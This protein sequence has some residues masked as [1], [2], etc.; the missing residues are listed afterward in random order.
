M[1]TL[2]LRPWTPDHAV[3]DNPPM[4]RSE[5][6]TLGVRVEVESELIRERSDATRN[7]WFFA[8][9]VQITNEGSR[10]VQL[11]SR[12]WIISDANGAVE[13]V[14]GRGVVG[15]QPMLRGGQSYRYTSFCPLR[16]SFGMMH[17]SFHMVPAGGEPFDAEIAPFALGEPELLQ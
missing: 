16:T 15:Q 5:A 7:H 10:T 9:H 13:H 4:T 14:R 6:V 3:V 2:D 17:G 8:Y 1:R 12:H 11:V